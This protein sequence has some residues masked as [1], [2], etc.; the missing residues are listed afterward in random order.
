MILSVTTVSSPFRGTPLVYIL[1]EKYESAPAVRTL[2]LGNLLASTIHMLSYLSPLTRYLPSSLLPLDFHT[3][4]RGLGFNH[5]SVKSLL[6]NLVMSS[7]GASRDCA[8]WDLTFTSSDEREAMNWATLNAKTW[9]RSYVSCM[10]ETDSPGA[11]L[12]ITSMFNPLYISSNL[13]GS[14]DY[15]AVH[16]RPSILNKHNPSHRPGRLGTRT[17]HV[18]EELDEERLDSLVNSMIFPGGV[19]LKSQRGNRSLHA[20]EL[21]ANDGVVPTF[22]QWHP[23]ECSDDICIH[24][25]DLPKDSTCHLCPESRAARPGIWHVIDIEEPTNHISIIPF[26]MGTEKQIRFW[27]EIGGWLRD[28]DAASQLT[29]HEN[30]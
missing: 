13:M 18:I 21:W 25:S 8:P 6:K 5:M 30:L 2:S 11:H 15:Y 23:G 12:P 4:C 22:S 17:Y 29:R 26:W 27:R 20:G 19:D 10:T 1:G 7:W 24:Y 28:V 3:E 16:P 14:F 9:Y